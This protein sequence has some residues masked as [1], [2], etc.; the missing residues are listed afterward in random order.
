MQSKNEKI[1]IRLILILSLIF[2]S[3]FSFGKSHSIHTISTSL[4]T[5]PGGIATNLQLWLRADRATNTVTEGANVSAWGDRSSNAYF[6]T[7]SVSATDYP[8]F[9]QD[10]INFNPSIEFDGTFT[11]DYSDGLQLGGDYIFGTGNGMHVFVACEP[12][13]DGEDFNY[14]FDFGNY[15]G[16]GYGFGFS[17]NKYNHYTSSANSGATFNS[18]HSKGAVPGLLE[19]E[20]IFNQGQYVRHNYQSIGYISQTLPNLNTSVINKATTYQSASNNNGP[21]SIGRKST[22]ANLSTNGG[23]I[24]NGKIAE[25]IVYNDK[26]SSADRNKIYTYLSVKY[27]ITTSVLYSS[28]TG[29]GFKSPLDGFHHDVVAVGRDDGS[30]LYQK[31]SKSVE[32]DNIIQLGY[33]T[34]APTNKLNTATLTNQSFIAIG[35]NDS[36][37]DAN[38][39]ANSLTINSKDYY[40]LSRIW[41]FQSTGTNNNAFLRVDVDDPQFDLPAL[42]VGS[43]GNYYLVM[44]DT[45][46]SLGTGTTVAPLNQIGSTSIWEYTEATVGSKFFSI[47]VQVT[48][49]ADA[50]TGNCTTTISG[51]DSGTYTL[52]DG[53]KICIEGAANFTGTINVNG[54]TID[55][56]ADNPQSFSIIKS[57]TGF[58]A[59]FNNYGTYISP[60]G[61]TTI[62]SSITYNNYGKMI[63][64]NNILLTNPIIN[65]DSLLMATVTASTTSSITNEDGGYLE[66][67]GLDAYGQ[68]SNTNGF[69]VISTSAEFRGTSDLNM[70]KGCMIT[71]SLSIKL[72]A[73]LN[74]LSCGTIIINTTSENAGNLTGEYAI[75]DLTPTGG[76][77]DTNTGTIGPNITSDACTN[78][79]QEICG[80][81][82]D[83]N[84]DGNIDEPQPGGVSEYLTL[85]LKADAGTNTT[86]D[87]QNITSWSDQSIHKYSADANTDATDYPVFNDDAINF[88]PG[89]TFDGTYTDDASDGLHLGNEYI[90][91]TGEGFHSFAVVKP[92]SSTGSR[93]YIFDFGFYSWGGYGFGYTN[94]SLHMY[95]NTGQG[96]DNISVNHFTGTRPALMEVDV[97]FENEQ[98][99]AQNG[100]PLSTEAITLTDLN[101]TKIAEADAYQTTISTKANGPVS[102]GRKSASSAIQNGNSR[103]FDGDIAEIILYD[104]DISQIDRQKI[105]TYLAIK[106]GITL[107]FNYVSASG[108]TLKN[109]ADGYAN[110]IGIIGR[111]DCSGIYQKQSRS[112]SDDAIL[113]LGA[114][115][116]EAT[117]AANTGIIADESFYVWG[118]N[119]QPVS[120]WGAYDIAVN[121][122]HFDIQDRIWRGTATGT[123][124]S[125][126]IP[127][128]NVDNPNFDLPALPAN[129]DG[130]Y[131]YLSDDDGD[132]TNGGTSFTQ[133]GEISPGI[134]ASLGGTATS[135]YMAIAVASPAEICDNNMD[136]DL[137]GDEDCDDSDCT[138]CEAQAPTL[139]K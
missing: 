96:G 6:A 138:C 53:E 78:C 89:I 9:R 41:K 29:V 137:D 84:Q 34:Y 109:V 27:G 58:S 24:F 38:W 90:T 107:A 28:S 132:F 57:N 103:I 42:P 125:D 63:F 111:E 59:E 112:V 114:V 82:T 46:S 21:V 135:Q 129:S 4:D 62:G 108:V 30:G 12:F 18:S 56:C 5:F 8:V 11:D 106:Y 69:V 99:V 98:S 50:C 14:L 131:Y 13:A 118:N 61:L 45:D 94:S 79:L 43:D 75:V 72:G 73:T 76:I 54:G 92:N 65:Y 119:N 32:P 25:V 66:I 83:D 64:N 2:P 93:K 139:S 80:N 20:V 101:L 134:W 39:T 15:N 71:N 37:L 136:D 97:D 128:I 22:A 116:I 86:T 68:F 47:A 60:G 3:I 105:S 87:G 127:Q 7:S 36:A 113:T 91:M 130:N 51:N 67:E 48:D 52:E 104:G 77:F 133:M 122:R 88:N 1:V 100:T 26:L 33:G 40:R 126:V 44:H 31:Q 35:N 74:G 70:T 120:A 121:G 19:F 124:I 115:S 17:D 81:N 85:W 110:D 102:I 10:G 16:Y 123:L 95:T 23:Q 117:N 49:P 55:N